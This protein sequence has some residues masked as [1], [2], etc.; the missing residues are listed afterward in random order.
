MRKSTLIL[1]ASLAFFAVEAAKNKCPSSTP[2]C[3]PPML[4]VKQINKRIP[5]FTFSLK[6]VLFNNDFVLTATNIQG[7]EQVMHSTLNR[8][9][10]GQLRDGPQLFSMAFLSMG[11]GEPITIKVKAKQGVES[12]QVQFIPRPLKV[13]QNGYTLNMQV[14]DPGRKTYHLLASGFAPFERVQLYT[15]S[16]GRQVRDILKADRCGRINSSLLHNTYEE[17]GG[18]AYLEIQGS[19]GKASINYPW[20]ESYEKDLQDRQKFERYI[21]RGS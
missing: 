18:T 11:L 4:E 9:S 2:S 12:A 20:G 8:A 7:E 19:R 16:S 1:L 14:I 17:I 15:C 5:A 3:A 6:N 13:E 21:L 10:D